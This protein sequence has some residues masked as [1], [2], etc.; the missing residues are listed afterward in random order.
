[1]RGFAGVVLATLVPATFLSL[2]S[3]IVI[4]ISCVVGNE[5][6]ILPFIGAIWS[7]SFLVMLAAAFGYFGD[8]LLDFAHFIT[9]GACTVIVRQIGSQE[10]SGCDGHITPTRSGVQVLES[11]VSDRQSLWSI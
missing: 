5:K 9:E 1:M 8:S 11:K 7:C 3:I 2:G 10:R 4:L 6:Q